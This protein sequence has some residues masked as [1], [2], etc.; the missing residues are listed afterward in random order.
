D[1]PPESR[2]V[3]YLFQEYAL[4]PHLDVFHNVRFGAR[5]GRLAEEMLDRFGITH[6]RHAGTRDLS[7]GERQ[8]VAV[9][10]ALAR[11]PD[12]LLLDEPLSALDA[13]TRA[14]A[15]RELAGVLRGADELAA[16]PASAFVA[17]F[18]GAVVLTGVATRG[19]VTVVELDGGGTISSTDPAE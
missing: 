16:R 8:R 2:R 10:R 1:L 12:V 4:F 17:D 9:A 19:D 7:G 3:G 14:A 18:T 15:A 13:S 6:L 11:E 5:D